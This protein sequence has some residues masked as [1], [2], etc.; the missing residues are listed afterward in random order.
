MRTLCPAPA[1]KDPAALRRW[2]D[3]R[4]DDIAQSASV[5]PQRAAAPTG[6][7]EVDGAL[8]GGLRTG[9]LHEWHAPGDGS[10]AR[11]RAWSPPLTLLAH[12]AVAA[13][14]ATAPDEQPGWIAW[15]GRRVWP[16][17]PALARLGGAPLVRRSLL[18]DPEVPGAP[19]IPGIPGAR[20]WA[21]D[22]A[23]RCPALVV[24][25]DGAGLALAETRRLQLSAESGASVGLLARPRW[26]RATRSAAATRWEVNAGVSAEGVQQWEIVLAACKGA[27]PLGPSTG[28]WLLERRCDGVIGVVPVLGVRHGEAALAS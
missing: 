21:I 24:V 23:L 18:V 26:D 5:K 7:P 16:Y 12:L 22:A 4:L 27:R 14:R 1:G 25:A 19:G 17:A 3:E 10:R 2:L 8:G 15:I 28:R 11:D 20:L 13:A 6:W 9:A